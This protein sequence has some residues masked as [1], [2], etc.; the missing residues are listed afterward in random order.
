[1]DI[2]HYNRKAWDKQVADGSRWTVPVDAAVIAAA[3]A[4]EWSIILTPTVPV[5]RQWFPPST[6]VDVLCLAAGGGQ[7]AP[8]LAA[9]GMRV[10]LLDNSPAQLAQD[11]LVAEREGLDLTIVAG[12]MAD[13][14]DFAA[15]SF[16]VIVHP[17]SNCFV[18]DV[19]PVWREA[20][21]VLRPGGVLLAGMMNPVYYIFDYEKMTAGEL[22]VRHALPYADTGSLDAAALEAHLAT[23]DPVEFSHTLEDQLGGQVAAGFRISGFYEDS[24][25]PEDNCALNRYLPAMFATCAVKPESR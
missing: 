13:L 25:G 3:R 20:Y 17:V 9:A 2:R 18:A 16:D 8:V 21:R 10:T 24:F 12:D 19:H 11:K 6:D 15:A 23:G 7:Q 14:G 1:L 22:V 4:G 5:P